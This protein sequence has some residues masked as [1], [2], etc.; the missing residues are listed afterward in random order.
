MIDGVR[1]L[2]SGDWVET[3]SALVEDMQGNWKI[4]YYK[5]MA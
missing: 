4:V 3:M 2:N 1:Y 5:D